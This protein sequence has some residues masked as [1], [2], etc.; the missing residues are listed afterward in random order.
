LFYLACQEGSASAEN[1]FVWVVPVPAL[2]P[3]RNKTEP[4]PEPWLLSREKPFK[5]R[6]NFDAAPAFASISSS[7]GGGRRSGLPESSSGLYAKAPVDPIHLPKD[8][9]FLIF[10]CLRFV[11]TNSIRLIR[12]LVTRL[13]HHALATSTM[14]AHRGFRRFRGCPSRRPPPLLP[15]A[16]LPPPAVP[17]LPVA[18]PRPRRRDCPSR[19]PPRPSF[20][21][22]RRRPRGCSSLSPHPCGCS[23]TAVADPSPSATRRVLSIC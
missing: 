21:A 18:G 10:H 3:I 15:V 17:W 19:L 5:I 1:G 20:R 11:P 6:P 4:L 22:A 13:H 7:V 2:S 8:F 9:F 12:A 16:A 14:G 23:S